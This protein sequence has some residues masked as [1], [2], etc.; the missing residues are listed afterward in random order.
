MLGVSHSATA[1]YSRAK[2]GSRPWAALA[3]RRPTF[4]FGAPSGAAAAAMR[5][6][7]HGKHSS[8]A[9]VDGARA[10]ACQ[11]VQS[12]LSPAAGCSS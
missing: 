9:I 1:G 6:V 8:A 11:L 2:R 3:A 4:L 7:A 5:S 12:L 10:R